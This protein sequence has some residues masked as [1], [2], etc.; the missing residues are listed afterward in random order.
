MPKPS[1]FYIG[2]MEFFSILLPG[3]LLV[4]AVV[5]RWHP[6][7][8]PPLVALITSR[9]AGW[10][11][12]ALAAY[13]AG[14][15][16]FLLASLL[17]SPV[18]D[19]YRRWRWPVAEDHC[20]PFAVEARKAYFRGDHGPDVPMNTFAW[21]K[22]VLRM[23]A[24]AASADVERYE[25]DSKFFRS[26]VI[27]IPVSGAIL[28]PTLPGLIALTVLLTALAF[29]AYADRRHKSTEWAYR[30]AVVL[31]ASKLPPPVPGRRLPG[32]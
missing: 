4:A 12:F 15:F 25:A 11:G 17:D 14:H 29:V 6:E 28:L 5:G 8:H 22:A 19:R 23:E 16:L 27:A 7:L 30:Y 13:A 3:S 20:Y 2:V 24:P 32:A 21:A 26:L 9:T 31:A 10:I 1:E 18:Y